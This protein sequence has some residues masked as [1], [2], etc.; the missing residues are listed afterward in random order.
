MG[1]YEIC[2]LE[3]RPSSRARSR[4]VVEIEVV[5]RMEA[6]RRRIAAEVAEVRAQRTVV[7]VFGVVR[8][9]QTVL[10]M[11]SPWVRMGW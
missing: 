8:R 7:V 9:M 2:E 11:E 1:T 10:E 6:V 3:E 5:L 4:V